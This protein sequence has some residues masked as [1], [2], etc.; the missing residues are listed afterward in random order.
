MDSKICLLIDDSDNDR[1]VFE[2]ALYNVDKG[3]CCITA[4]S[5]LQALRTLSQHESFAPDYIFVDLHMPRVDGKRCLTL[6]KQLNHLR[7]TPVITYSYA[8]AAQDIEDTRRLGAV[9]HI[10][11]PSDIEQLEKKLQAFF[12]EYPQNG[13]IYEY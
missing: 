12:A 11:K 8:V 13:A 5:S 2:M 3:I 1:E 6:L 7:N 10:N 4:S 9:A